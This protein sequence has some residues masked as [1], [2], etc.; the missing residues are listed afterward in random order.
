MRGDCSLTRLAR[1][2][3]RYLTWDIQQ[4]LHLNAS[5]CW[6]TFRK[7]RIRPLK[8]QSRRCP[9]AQNLGSPTPMW[10]TYAPSTAVAHQRGM[11]RHPSPAHLTGRSHQ[12][13]Q[14]RRKDQG[15]CTH[16]HLHAISLPS[17]LARP[18]EHFSQGIQQAFR[19]WQH[20]LSLRDI[21]LIVP[22]ESQ[23]QGRELWP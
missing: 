7:G 1:S 3:V 23:G 18:N 14:A 2:F 10:A 17:N 5:R 4:T 11:E 9:G 20:F 16:H 15:M 12:R 6:F 13:R 21:A 22:A 8:S 19:G